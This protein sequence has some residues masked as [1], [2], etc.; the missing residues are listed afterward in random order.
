MLCFLI[1]A[2]GV[3]CEKTLVVYNNLVLRHFFMGNSAS[4]AA[5]KLPKRAE[6]PS[7]ASNRTLDST[8]R[9]DGVNR[10]HARDKLASEHKTEGL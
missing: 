3:L 8:N 6:P 7:W 10:E 9:P 2:A 5:R 1:N 4:R